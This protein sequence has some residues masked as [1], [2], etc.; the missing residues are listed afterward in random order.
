MFLKRYKDAFAKRL[1]RT[2]IRAGYCSRPR[3][4][5]IG[6][7]KG[8]TTALYYFLA[9]HPNIIPGTEKEIGFFS[10]ELFE[11]WFDN[12]NHHIL[13]SRHGT[14]FFDRRLYPRAAAWYHSHFPLPHKLGDRC[15]TYE[16]T[17]EYLY[18]PG[19]AER[20]HKYDSKMKLIAILRDP[21]ER[22]FAAWNMYYNEFDHGIYRPL[23]EV[24]DFDEAVQDELNEI[25]SG[26]RISDPGYVRRGL[27]HEQLL[28]YFQLFERDQMLILSSRELKNNTSCV[29]DQ[30]IEFLGLPE[31]SHRGAWP[32]YL[33]GKYKRE[34]SQKTLRLL[35][36]FY[37]P[38]NE[39][40]YDMLNRD[41]G[42]Q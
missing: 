28:R 42:W 10:P 23:K 4:L 22:A 9:E 18:Y 31:Y 26:S 1:R 7:Q 40:L 5:I 17:P 29:I 11:Y 41:F 21:V 33:V 39:K 16:A 34:I 27:Y 25:E 20:I 2:L 19:V 38:Y 36:E 3:F 24:R 12:P 35:R 32:S 8:G 14:D 37:G 6:A 15:I 30:V 13:C